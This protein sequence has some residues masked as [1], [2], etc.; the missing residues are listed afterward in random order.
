MKPLDD[1]LIKLLAMPQKRA[2]VN[3]GPEY[4]TATLLTDSIERR[5]PIPVG[6]TREFAFGNT[7]EEAVE[8]AVYMGID[9]GLLEEMDRILGGHIE[10]PADP[11]AAMIA[12]DGPARAAFDNAPFTY[13]GGLVKIL[14]C[15]TIR[16]EPDAREFF[17]A[18]TGPM[19]RFK[20]GSNAKPAI[21]GLTTVHDGKARGIGFCSEIGDE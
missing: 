17:K 10:K 7:F 6:E 19:K 9:R 18:A 16:H 15:K 13:T 11:N 21:Q 8:E 20:F 4:I 1:D 2:P 5:I 12:R 3:D 14:D